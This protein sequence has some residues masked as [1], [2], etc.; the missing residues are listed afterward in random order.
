MKLCPIT[1]RITF[2]PYLETQQFL[3]QPVLEDEV[4][5]LHGIKFN[6][7]TLIGATK[8]IIDIL[9]KEFL[10]TVDFRC[11]FFALIQKCKTL[12]GV[13]MDTMVK[14]INKYMDDLRLQGI[15]GIMLASS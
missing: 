2:N 13:P 8:T 9:E 4:P 10:Q 6:T 14:K 3:K 7:C 5:R 11:L 12:F 15:A 1:Y